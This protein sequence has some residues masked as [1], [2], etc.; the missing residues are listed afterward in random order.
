MMRPF[1]RSLALFA[2]AVIIAAAPVI[3]ATQA[4]FVP[5][6]SLSAAGNAILGSPTAKTKVVEYMSYACGHCAHFHGAEYKTLRDGRMKAGTAS[7][8]I[9]PVAHN[10][11]GIAAAMAVQC[12][13]PGR[14]YRNHALFLDKQNVW[15]GKVVKAPPATAKTFETGD[16][17]SRMKAIARYAGFYEMMAGRNVSEAQLNAC[18]SDPAA[19]DRVIKNTDTLAALISTVPTPTFLVNGK[20]AGGTG[21]TADLLPALGD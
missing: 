16:G 6:V 14:Y 1:T 10:M 4:A 5:K 17:P 8:E 19:F 2:G 20:L 21:N 7:L 12:G 11:A 18:L 3:A 15:L 9:R 13:G